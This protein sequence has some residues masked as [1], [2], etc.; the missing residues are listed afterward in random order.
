MKARISILLFVLPLLI[1][2]QPLPPRRS[3]DLQVLATTR[4]SQAFV[5]PEGGNYS[6]FLNDQLVYPK[7]KRR[8]WFAGYTNWHT[9]LS[10]IIWSPD[11][12][13]VALVDE[14]YNWEYLDPFNHD[15][16]GSVTNKHLY[17]A[18]IS[19]NGQVA[20]YALND[21]GPPFELHWLPNDKL[22]LNGRIFDLQAEPPQPIP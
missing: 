1:R 2:D 18:I 20:S 21:V 14:V 5:T 15:F 13:R 6:L 7:K 11:S 12:R 8:R 17:L 22:V 3:P 10:E 4:V 19:R 16:T 9:F